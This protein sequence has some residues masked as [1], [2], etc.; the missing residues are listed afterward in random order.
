[1]VVI[2]TVGLLA[3]VRFSKTLEVMDLVSDIFLKKHQPKEKNRRFGKKR[4]KKKNDK[5]RA[6]TTS[7]SG[8]RLDQP[9]DS[10]NLEQRQL[11]QTSFGD[12]STR[13]AMLAT[14]TNKEESESDGDCG[15]SHQGFVV[16]L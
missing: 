14:M 5:T 6:V 9:M 2:W 4:Q 1:M 7:D 11:L 12:D 3:R 13:D 10:A 8:C 15:G 16:F